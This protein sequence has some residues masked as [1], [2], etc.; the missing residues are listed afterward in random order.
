MGWLPP[1]AFRKNYTNVRTAATFD[2]PGLVS[3]LYPLLHEMDDL[4]CQNLPDYYQFAHTAALSMRRPEGEEDDLSRIEKT[5]EYR[6]YLEAAAKCD[7]ISPDFQSD[8]EIN[9]EYAGRVRDPLQVIKNLDPWNFLYTIRGTAFS[10]VELNRNIIFKAHEDGGNV[11]GTCVCMT[12]LGDFVGGRIVFP[13]YGYSAEVEHGDVLICDNNK[14]LH[15]NLG[16]IVGERF[17]VVA[18]LHK[19]LLHRTPEEG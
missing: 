6:D 14:E 17:S 4:I 18:F 9:A 10:T 1:K 7:P 3:S 12:A 19:S 16:P 8:E 11:R 13:R 5:P 15:G 2:Q